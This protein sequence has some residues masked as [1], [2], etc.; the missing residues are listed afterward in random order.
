LVQTPLAEGSM[1]EQRKHFKEKSDLFHKAN[2]YAKSLITSALTEESYQ[3]IC[4]I[5]HVLLSEYQSFKSSWISSSDEKRSVDE[6]AM[7]L[8][9][10]VR[11]VKSG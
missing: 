10:F 5:L 3:K 7:Q 8:C 2:S 11:D 4:K 9:S 6:L 1:A